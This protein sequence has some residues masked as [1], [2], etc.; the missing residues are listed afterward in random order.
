MLT[1]REFGLKGFLGAIAGILGFRAKQ[2]SAEYMTFL[3]AVDSDGKP[4]LAGFTKAEIEADPRKLEPI[5]L[6]D[7][8]YW[9]RIEHM[10][11]VPKNQ[12]CPSRVILVRTLLG[13]VIVCYPVWHPDKRELFYEFPEGAEYWAEF[14][15]YGLARL[16]REHEIKEIKAGRREE[17]VAWLVAG[18]FTG[19]GAGPRGANP[20]I[21]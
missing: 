4:C 18:S 3:E 12:F 2:A 10:P 21:S 8:L 14:P 6:M 1:R 19:K 15:M 7:F 5:G 17:K 9:Q 11:P 16:D 13:H 20:K